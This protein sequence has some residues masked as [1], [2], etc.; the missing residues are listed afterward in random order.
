MLPWLVLLVETEAEVIQIVQI[1]SQNK[2]QLTFRAAGT[3]LSGQ[4]VTDQVLVVL[5][6]S[7]W[8]KYQISPDGSSIKLEAGIIGAQANRWLAKFKRQ[9]GPD[10]GSIEA[11]KIG[12]II[13]N[14]SSGMCCGTTKNSYATLENLRA[15]FSDG[16]LF[17]SSNPD[18]VT[19]FK[20]THAE[21]ITKISQIRDQ[22]RADAALSQFIR[23][24][25]AIKNTSGYSLNAFIDYDDPI[26]IIERLLIGSEGTLAFISEVTLQTIPIEEHRALNLIYG[27]LTDLINLTVQISGYDISSG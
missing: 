26:K 6:S 5:S 25:F 20:Q 24:K 4:A 10:P 18:E 11:A 27:K 1:A 2:I 21:L 15:V 22:I 7:S 12:G 8:Q 16:S 19:Q 3:S 23:K 14:N 9:I 13:A 17:D